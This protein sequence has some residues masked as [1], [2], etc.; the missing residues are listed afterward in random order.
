MAGE[1]E[2]KKAEIGLGVTDETFH[3]YQRLISMLGTVFDQ[4]TKIQGSARNINLGG[5]SFNDPDKAGFTEQ[6]AGLQRDL[7][8]LLN[9][10]RQ[11]TP[12]AQINSAIL[13]NQRANLQYSDS[14]VDL[15]MTKNANA[16]AERRVMLQKQQNVAAEA[17]RAYAIEQIGL[18]REIQQVTERVAIAQERYR[19][20][21]V[22]TDVTAATAAKR[23]IR[24]GRDRLNQLQEE[25]NLRER[26]AK[27]RLG[28]VLDAGGDSSIANAQLAAVTAGKAE[29]REA[30]R[31]VAAAVRQAE[32]QANAQLRAAQAPID[33]AFTVAT[34]ED[35]RRYVDANIA[36]GRVG[37]DRTRLEQLRD[38][39]AA[40]QQAE[41]EA[42]QAALDRQGAKVGPTRERLFALRDKVA[43]QQQKEAEAEQAALDRQGAQVGPARERLLALRDKVAAQQQKEAQAEQEAL[44]RQG[45]QV[46][47]DRVRLQALRDRVAAQQQK[48]ADAEQ[49]VLNRQGA[50]VG[51]D[52]ARLQALRDKVAAQQQKEAEAEQAALNRQGAQFGPDRSTIYKLRDQLWEQQK[53]SDTIFETMLRQAQIYNKKWE[54]DQKKQAGVGQS[55]ADIRQRRYGQVFGDGG[56]ALALT[57]TGLTAN[58]MLTRGV[59]TAFADAIRFT[60]EYGEA[61]AHLRT[62]TNASDGQMQT[63][64][65]TIEGVSNA[66]RYSAVDLTRAAASLSETGVTASQ[67][68]VALK[69]VAD[70]ATA[71]GEDFATTVDTVTGALGAFKLSATD[72]VQVTNMI[73]QAVNGSRLT[74]EKLKGSFETTGET[75]S[76]AGVSFK[77][78]LAA[79]EAIANTGSASG[80][81]LSTG[82]R[83]LLID[84][85]KP[86]QNFKMILAQVGLTEE[87][88]NVKTQGL[89]GAMRNLHDAGFTAAD[90][91]QSFNAR[92]SAAFTALS[93]N[94]GA[95]ATFEGQL[96]NTD[97]ATRATT[98]QMDT[99]GAQFD[100][101]K[102]QT[103][104]L[105]GE[106][107]TPLLFGF[108]ELIKLASDLETNMR[109]AGAGVEVIG[110]ALG[111]A[112]LAGAGRYVGGL[113]G[114][115]T[116]M[117]VGGFKAAAAAAE[118]GGQMGVIVAA[119]AAAVAGIAYLV[120]A[121]SDT[122][123]AFDAQVTA[124]KAAKDA[125]SESQQGMDSLGRTIETLG[126]KMVAL[127]QH[128]ELLKREIDD[129]A[130]TFEKYG[131]QLD[132]SAIHK[133][134]DLID[135]LQRLHG[136]MGQRYELNT[137][138]V[139]VQ[140]DRLKDETLKK[141]ADSGKDFT[142]ATAA[143]PQ[144]RINRAR[145]TSV[146]VTGDTGDIVESLGDISIL[147]SGRRSRG[148]LPVSGV[149][150]ANLGQLTAYLGEL[151]DP[152]KV[153]A[154]QAGAAQGLNA[155]P[156]PTTADEV[157]KA[158]ERI[159][160]AS[161]A[162]NA[163][164]N[165][166]N[167]G[168][169]NP[170]ATLQQKQTAG[171]VEQLF[172]NYQAAL[173]GTRVVLETL[174][175]TLSEQVTVK[176]QQDQ[177]A[178]ERSPGVAARTAGID[179]VLRAAERVLTSG[180]GVNRSLDDLWTAQTM[181]ESGRRQ[182][183]RDGKPLRSPK[184][185]VG[186]AQVMEGTGPEAAADAGVDWDRDKWLNDPAYNE[187]I[188][189]A[190]M[191]KLMKKYRDNNTLSLA[192]YN[193][194][195]GNVDSLLKTAGDFRNPASGITESDF[196][197]AIT[198]RSKSTETADYIARV[199][200]GA[201]AGA[202]GQYYA[203]KNNRE[204][205]VA[206]Q[207]A[208]ELVQQLKAAF[209]LAVKDKNLPEQA[210]ITIQ[211]DRAKTSL[212]AFETEYN[213][214]REAAAPALRKVA[215]A[216]E[217]A[218]EAQLG[219]L[220]KQINASTD[221]DDIQVKRDDTKALITQKYQTQIDVLKSSSQI[222]KGPEGAPTY[223]AEV[224]AQIRSLQDELA[225]KLRSQDEAVAHH[226]ETVTKALEDA[227]LKEQLKKDAQEFNAFMSR[228]GL[229]MKA[230]DTQL[231]VD[232]RRNAQPLRD[233][234]SQAAYMNDPRYSAQFSGVQ[235]QSLS[236]RQA[237]DQ[238]VKDQAD[239]ARQQRRQLEL[240]AF[241]AQA[242]A[243][244][245]TLNNRQAA[246]EAEVAG[247]RNLPESAPE[248]E[249]AQ[250]A[251]NQTLNEQLALTGRI[252]ELER[253]QTKNAEDR[254]ET[255]SRINA[256]KA[257]PLTLGEGILDANANYI[258]MH[259]ETAQALDGYN[260]M[261]STTQN[262]LAGFFDTI[263][264][265]SA[266]A[267]EAMKAFARS[268]LQSI[269][270]IM[271]Q[272]AALSLVKSILGAFGSAGASSAGAGA[273]VQ[274][275]GPMDLG[276]GTV[277][278]LPAIQGGVV[279]EGVI[280]RGGAISRFAGGG[281]VNG[282]VSTRD[283]VL[284]LL[285]PGEVV[286]NDGAVSAVGEDFLNGLNAQGN[287]V[288]SRSQPAP[289]PKRDR[290]P[291]HV[292]VWVVAPDQ[293][294]QLG[295]RD[296]VATISDDITRGGTTKQLIRQVALG[297]S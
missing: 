53:K 3:S 187:K 251:L 24:D 147:P 179:R 1:N 20:A 211:L 149:T 276:S 136:Q 85:E 183:G 171:G 104:L 39:V 184:G 168:A 61:L 98:Q 33:R 60:V 88:I 291:D 44:N 241:A 213:K 163:A 185:A 152:A 70:L 11:G 208:A 280:T 231:K 135:A 237:A 160:N 166:V 79:T 285:K 91:M 162:L 259:D 150:Q 132:R 215:Q 264:T 92:S 173:N 190:Y 249:R 114:G 130:K 177:S 122:N 13:A 29:L 146:L 256:K 119:A 244:R 196:I 294:P 59:A 207:Q 105:V 128:P 21:L 219:A 227:K 142:A 52:R 199:G 134:E 151:V 243:E 116:G 5:V 50:K 238:D 38:R 32:T 255:E 148:T 236:F 193:W 108:K 101:F 203:L 250:K 97:A 287:R 137:N 87:D 295:P 225:A 188:G 279:G 65:E 62:I 158:I 103:S 35:R 64:R 82:L 14:R 154:F 56:A 165:V 138:I 15:E 96:N 271:E 4:L 229:D 194:G 36:A 49:A 37:P 144:D 258:R 94:L 216:E 45:A 55:D 95:M 200:G 224:E 155:Y 7:R 174:Q 110:T 205:A 289:A 77:E 240:D 111:G 218:L 40:Q 16:A 31:M 129:V 18:S 292:N 25:L 232:L 113:A 63:F 247:F 212:A 67:M 275:G 274:V 220:N 66:T 172:S 176:G 80:A 131:E 118:V 100:R 115:L 19:N 145:D 246:Q 248:R 277:T 290:V 9:A 206:A 195:Q 74:M 72:S 125:Q 10:I 257:T 202:L 42:G 217:R 51:P 167:T 90:A 233:D 126:H 157:A 8:T 278:A 239:F 143:G 121:L 6:L 296:I 117:A 284:A 253:D 181:A 242:Q 260:Q 175:R 89:Y 265:K 78:L 189:K 81:T 192:A 230:G 262:N 41:A 178:Y 297:Q 47:P 204:M 141:L 30:Q 133:T 261:I 107:F 68:K 127:N 23:E 288:I 159:D 34:A 156:E 254:L 286:M 180:S 26:G 267:G 209:D 75:A 270:S 58:Y 84:L 46:G 210:S 48:E 71:T 139:S 221:I 12:N 86:S 282:P 93:G 22:S 109:G 54:E 191:G 214:K 112:A 73:A 273:D 245:I 102:N 76:E 57:Q 182:F 2:I 170:N 106:A 123:K 223:S 201:G 69:G 164:R 120:R 124:V 186:V 28:N 83:Q 228:L 43:A 281:R 269:L 235:R 266:S 153:A 293:K 252:G 169:L 268:F 27:V 272:Q 283:S 161:G 198:A 222:L 17:S 263:L 197:D 226:I 140:L 234:A 99:L